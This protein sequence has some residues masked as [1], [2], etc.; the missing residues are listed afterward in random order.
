MKNRETSEQLSEWIQD[1]ESPF[2]GYSPSLK[3]DVIITS[4]LHTGTKSFS[5]LL[6][7]I[8]RYVSLLRQVCF[9]KN[10]YHLLI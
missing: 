3:A 5:H 10:I 6:T 2:K 8:E 9:I 7:A 1:E 4:L